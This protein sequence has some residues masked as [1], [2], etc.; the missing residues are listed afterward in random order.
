V[1]AIVGQF[2]AIEIHPALVLTANAAIFYDAAV[3]DANLSAVASVTYNFGDGFSI[4]LVGLP[5]ELAHAGAHM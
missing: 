5:A 3:V 1:L 4:S 2:Q